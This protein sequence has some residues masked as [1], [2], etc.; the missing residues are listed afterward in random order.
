MNIREKYNINTIGRGERVMLFAHG[1][2]CDQN[3]W[4]FITPAFQEDYTLVLFDYIGAGKSDLGAYSTHKYSSLQAYAED[5]LEICHQLELWDVIFV[6]HS[7]SSMIGMLAALKEPSR[8]SKLVMIGPSPCYINKDGYIG[9][10][11]EA[12][13]HGLLESLESNYL[14]WS[15]TMAPA[16]MGNP[17]QPEL[18]EELTNSFCRTN[19]EVAS[20]FAK[21]TFLSDNREDLQ[22]LAIDTLLLQCTEDVIAPME[23]GHYVHQQIRN[24][25]LA[26]LNATGHCPHMSAPRETIQAIKQ[27]IS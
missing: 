18:S 1:Y 12:D 4:R 13:I 21:V 11:S 23:V 27:F 10:F 9:G 15:S 16:I 8:F 3:M 26:I 24:S 20:Q 5:I 14:G 6:G 19:P 7:V 22:K 2:G 25:E 17:D